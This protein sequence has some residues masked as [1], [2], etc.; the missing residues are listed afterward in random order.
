VISK[1]RPLVL[2]SASPRRRELLAG[3]GLP[4]RVV[5]GEADESE[6]PGESVEGYLERVV[7]EK[8]K[9]VAARIEGSFSAVLVADTIVVLDG[10]ILGKPDNVAQAAELVARIVG[11]THRVFTRYAI[12]PAHAPGT[13]AM[14]R[15]VE[16]AVTMRA[17]NRE[18]VERYARTGEGLDKAGAYAAQGIGAFLIERI[19]G[20]HSN[21][22]GLPVCEVVLDLKATGLLAAFP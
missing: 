19:E 14:A 13:P 21:V 1:E 6:R 22:I 9:A 3:L 20:S 12:A 4:L 16:S 2:G 15:S 11:R 17:A 8:L 10:E 5:V 18:E 7:G